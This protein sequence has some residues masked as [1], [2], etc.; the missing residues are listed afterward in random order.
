MK[1]LYFLNDLE[2]EIL[3]IELALEQQPQSVIQ[4]S[5]FWLMLEFGRLKL[6]VDTVF[7]IDLTVIFVATFVLQI[8]SMTRSYIRAIHR[9]R[10][11]ISPGIVGQVLQAISIACL[12]GPKIIVLSVSLLNFTYLHPIIGLAHFGV[13]RLLLSLI[14]I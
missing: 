1:Q 11:P 9:R 10:Y 3:I 12:I 7:G 4:C 8:V 6:L 5:I 14:H 2:S 13:I